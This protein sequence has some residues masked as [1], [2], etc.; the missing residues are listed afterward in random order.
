MKTATKRIHLPENNLWQ[1][2]DEKRSERIRHELSP[3]SLSKRMARG[4]LS[5][6]HSLLGNR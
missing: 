2:A 3:E 6:L 5:R 1:W 4:I